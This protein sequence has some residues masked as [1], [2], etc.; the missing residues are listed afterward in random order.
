MMTPQEAFRVFCYADWAMGLAGVVAF[1]M[2]IGWAIAAILPRYK[3]RRRRVLL[4]ALICLLVVVMFWATQTSVLIPFFN[5]QMT[6]PLAVLFVLPVVVMLAG[7]IVSV[8]Y[9]VRAIRRRTGTER[10]AM[11]LKSLLGVVVFGVG[12]APHT[13]AML[14]PILLVEE[15]H[16][17]RAGT[18]KRAGDPAPDFDLATVEGTPFHLVDLRGRVIVVNFF[19]TSCG[20]CQMELPQLQAVW[21]EF[22]SNG[23]FRMLV[24]GREES[25]DTIKAF[26]QKHGFTFPMAADRDGSIY[27]KFASRCIPR[28]FLISR[29]GT[30]VYQWTGHY[31]AEISKLRKLLSRE[32]ARKD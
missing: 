11:V 10:R 2:S 24:V 22:R 23:D 32:L 18:L 14:T 31:E 20:P 8:T 12:A 30:I 27:K 1:C 6:V 28:T 7:L 29:Q 17:N 13:V 4:R 21:D 9:G 25:D 19:A 26:R 16:S 5:Q 15:D 3:G